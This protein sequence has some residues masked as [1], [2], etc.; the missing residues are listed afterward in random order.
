MIIGWLTLVLGGPAVAADGPVAM[1]EAAN[2]AWKRCRTEF[3]GG[4]PE[5]SVASCTEAHR[6]YADALP[7]DHARVRELRDALVA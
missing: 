7:N 1:V 4:Q 2:A 6:L 5:A 3:E